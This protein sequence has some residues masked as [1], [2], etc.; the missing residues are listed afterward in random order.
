MQKSIYSETNKLFVEW[1]KKAREEKGLT[2]RDVGTL[3]GVH[4]SIIGKIET[5]ERRMDFAEFITFCEV[6]DLDAKKA[7]E[8]VTHRRRL[9]KRS[10]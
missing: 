4:H 10:L 5:Q 6:L 7:V 8:Y 9:S 3:L 1:L 2:L